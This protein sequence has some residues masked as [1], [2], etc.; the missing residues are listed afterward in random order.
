MIDIILNRLNGIPPIEDSEYPLSLP[1][2]PFM[3]IKLSDNWNYWDEGKKN[4]WV[5]WI[6]AGICAHEMMT[7]G[8]IKDASKNFYGK[9][10]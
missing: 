3:A 10:S 1:H 8:E 7:L 6:Q 4:R 2:L 5:G 9:T